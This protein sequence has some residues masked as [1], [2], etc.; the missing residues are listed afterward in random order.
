MQHVGKQRVRLLSSCQLPQFQAITRQLWA[1][2]HGTCTARTLMQHAS[3]LL[4]GSTGCSTLQAMQ[5]P[6]L[7]LHQSGL[8]CKYVYTYSHRGAFFTTSVD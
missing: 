2:V 4:K 1:E 3:T 6:E 7:V 8:P 5:N